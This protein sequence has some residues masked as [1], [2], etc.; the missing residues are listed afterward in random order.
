MTH[1]TAVAAQ[2]HIWRRYKTS[3]DIDLG[4]DSL[5]VKREGDLIY[6]LQRTVPNNVVGIAYLQKLVNY[7]GPASAMLY[8]ELTIKCQ[9]KTISL[10]GRWLGDSHRQVIW[11]DKPKPPDFKTIES[12]GD[13][14]YLHTALCVMGDL[15]QR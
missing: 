7:R 3:R 12:G 14:N 5:S 15:V 1:Y 8:N 6:V 13:F 11:G 9:D 10:R 2:E 4:Y